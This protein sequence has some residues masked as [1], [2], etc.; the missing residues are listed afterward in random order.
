MKVT[1]DPAQT[2]LVSVEIV[3]LTGFKGFTM[4]VL[5]ALAEEQGPVV[6]STRVAVPLKPA[7]GVQVALRSL[8]E[9]L[10]VPPAEELQLPPMALPPTDPP[11]AAEVCP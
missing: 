6:V 7:G 10:N 1:L 9:G 8:A 4:I 11:K 3:R 5:L 2:G